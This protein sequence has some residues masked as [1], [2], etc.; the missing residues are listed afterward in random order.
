MIIHNPQS[1]TKLLG[2]ILAEAS[3][4]LHL[5]SILVLP[6]P[7]PPPHP[8]TNVDNV[9][10]NIL[11]KPLPVFLTNI[12]MG[13]PRGEEIHL[14]HTDKLARYI[15]PTSFV[16]DCKNTKM[17]KSYNRFIAPNNPLYQILCHYILLNLCYCLFKL[18]DHSCNESQ[19]FVTCNREQ[20]ESV[21]N[22]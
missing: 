13:R 7:P 22:K 3:F 21:S 2:K 10:Q 8:Q 11:C 5:Q 15:F 18:W 19:F 1:W 20:C 12:G 4:D 9:M 6:P 17:T 16:Q 14:Y